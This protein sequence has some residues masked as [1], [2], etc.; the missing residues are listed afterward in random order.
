VI[1]VA[2]PFPP[3]PPN[4]LGKELEAFPPTAPAPPPPPP[5][6]LEQ[7]GMMEHLHHYFL[8]V[9]LLGVYYL[10]DPDPTYLLFPAPEPP[11][12]PQGPATTT[13]TC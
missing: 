8:E 3:A 10:T 4:T 7:T 2:K 1:D 5:T 13:T 11:T 9:D 6:Y 12:P